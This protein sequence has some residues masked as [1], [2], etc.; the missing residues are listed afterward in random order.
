MT[1]LLLGLALTPLVIEHSKAIEVLSERLEGIDREIDR[2][3]AANEEVHRLDKRIVIL[4]TQV[5]ELKRASEEADRRRWTLLLALFGVILTLV[6]NIL[7][8]LI[9]R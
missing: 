9:R 7:L 2:F 8:T 3:E 6:A 4:E 5:I 1:R